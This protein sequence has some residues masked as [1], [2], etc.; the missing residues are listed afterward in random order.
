MSR[1]LSPTYTERFAD[2]VAA[3]YMFTFR[4]GITLGTTPTDSSTDSLTGDAP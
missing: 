2:H 3:P 4:P 1:F